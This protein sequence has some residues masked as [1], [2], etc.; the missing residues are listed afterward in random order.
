MFQP[1]WVFKFYGNKRYITSAKTVSLY[2]LLYLLN[3]KNVSKLL[4]YRDKY[5]RVKSRIS[6]YKPISILAQVTRKPY[7]PELLLSKCSV[8][9]G[10]SGDFLGILP[11]ISE[12]LLWRIPMND[13]F[14]NIYLPW[15]CLSLQRQ[16]KP[17]LNETFYLAY[18]CP[19]HK[20][21]Y[22]FALQQDYHKVVE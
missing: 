17:N 16:K 18:F 14:F 3:I 22:I 1:L 13:C 21:L 6:K 19:P 15:C 12:Q 10:N 2:K 8:E 4:N 11:N 7:G 5:L 9:E 20:C